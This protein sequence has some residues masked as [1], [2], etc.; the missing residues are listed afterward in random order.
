MNVR[1]AYGLLLISTGIGFFLILILALFN[2]I[3]INELQKLLTLSYLIVI[4]GL[5]LLIIDLKVR[6]RVKSNVPVRIRQILILITCM[7]FVVSAL[8][9]NI[10]FLLPAIIYLE[11]SIL[12]AF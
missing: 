11:C 12:V 1:K 10:N 3:G 5:F 8:S 7:L 6:R 9:K 2:V 4:V